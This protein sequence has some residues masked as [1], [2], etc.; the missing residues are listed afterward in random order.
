MAGG[1]RVEAFVEKPDR[2]RAEDYL[3]RGDYFWNSGIF[4]LHARTFLKELR[5]S[6][7]ARSW[8]RRATRS[9]KA[10]EDLGFLRLDQAAFA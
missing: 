5:A 10:T 2:E 8:T 4:V 7:A 9:Q 3:A 6:R 1:F